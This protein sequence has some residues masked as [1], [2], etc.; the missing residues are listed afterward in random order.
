MKMSKTY[1]LKQEENK[2]Y[3]VYIHK[4]TEPYKLGLY[5]AEY[6]NTEKKANRLFT[7]KKKIDCIKYNTI[8]FMSKEKLR[9]LHMTGMCNV[10]AVINMSYTS[11]KEYMELL[12]SNYSEIDFL[13]VYRDKKWICYAGYQIGE[14]R[15]IEEIYLNSLIPT[16]QSF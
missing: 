10:F 4:D 3:L 14:K 5:L 8:Y 7:L 15:I 11:I 6:F 2:T 1:L 13:Y 12:T 16:N 9:E